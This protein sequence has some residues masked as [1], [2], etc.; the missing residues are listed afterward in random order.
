M[1]WWAGSAGAVGTEGGDV[2]AGLCAD[3]P[4][5]DGQQMPRET[6]TRKRSQETAAAATGCAG[7]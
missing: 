4:P 7:R 3:E 1:G 2:A 5:E 6:R